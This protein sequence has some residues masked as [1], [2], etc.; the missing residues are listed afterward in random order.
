MGAPPI[1]LRCAALGDGVVRAIEWK[2]TSLRLLD[3]RKLPAVCEYVEC[4]TADDVAEAIRSMVVRGA[5][6]IGAAA[7]YGI[8]LGAK[9][10]LGRDDETFWGK[11][12]AILD[13][14]SKTRPTAVNLF[15][16]IDRMRKRAEALRGRA[17]SEVIQALE[18]EAEAIF[19][20]DAQINRRIG[21]H[22]AELIQHGDGVLTH[23]N[24]GS[25]ATAEYG[26]ALG[27]I[28]AAHAAGKGIHVYAGETRPFLQGA[29]LTAW[30][31]LQEGIPATLITDNAAAHL[32]KQ[33][34]IQRVIVGADRV[35]ANG[36]VVNK[37]GTYALAVL[38]KAHGIPFYAAVPLSTID[39]EVPSGDAV[40]IEERDPAEVTHVFGVRVAPE[41]I[42]V[43]NP[44][45]DATPHELVTAIITEEGVIYPPYDR[46]L[47]SLF[48]AR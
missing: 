8:T 45:F 27:V 1:S 3:Q 18:E 41:G 38:A 19:R 42:G 21:M 2:Q 43:L 24:T 30:E 10:L 44:A 12:E 34:R 6:A 26:T 5:P 32:M 13:Q 11:F 37:I 17:H 15:W 46:A 40:A 47:G 9:H 23:C 22:G 20:E 4:R 31:L 39:L 7:A 14:M 35:A 16:A 36:D 33:G 28:R 25:L 48:D 29:R